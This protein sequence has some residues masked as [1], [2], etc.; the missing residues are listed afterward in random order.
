MPFTGRAPIK[1]ILYLPG[2]LKL[3]CKRITVA[4]P[5]LFFF[6]RLYAQTPFP[7]P[8]RLLVYAE[9]ELAFGSFFTGA[10]GGTVTITPEG[11]R[12]VSGTITALTS[13]SGT[14]AIFNVRLTHGRMVHILFPVSASLIRIGGGE[15]MIVTDFVSDKQGNNFVTTA[16]HPFVNPVK[17]G[18]TLHAGNIAENPPGDYAGSFTVTFVQE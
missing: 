13:L 16:A 18:A 6:A 15:S 12:T 2:F 17:V 8:N 4:F 14:P 1:N 10:S 3:L 5:L 11:N 7:P 9:Q